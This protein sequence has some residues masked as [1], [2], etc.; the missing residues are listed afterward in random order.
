MVKRA[1]DESEEK[2]AFRF[3]PPS[4]RGFN[5]PK[6]KLDSDMSVAQ[7]SP[8]KETKEDIES[9][10]N[11]EKVDPSPRLERLECGGIAL[12]VDGDVS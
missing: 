2:N 1:F 6:V 9:L 7:E 10:D 5:S 12:W 11:R 8:E 4:F 3:E